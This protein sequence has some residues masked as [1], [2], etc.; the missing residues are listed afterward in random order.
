MHHPDTS[1]PTSRNLWALLPVLAVG[2]AMV[3]GLAPQGEPVD[4]ASTSAVSAAP[5]DVAGAQI[6]ASAS[7]DEPMA[8]FGQ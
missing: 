2:L 5:L 4:V 6:D 1:F 3:G 7:A 8:R